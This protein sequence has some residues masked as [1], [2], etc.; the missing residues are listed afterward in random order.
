MKLCP[1]HRS[2]IAMSGRVAQVPGEVSRIIEDAWPRRQVAR[3]SKI[4]L[5][6]KKLCPVHRS[7]IAMSGR[8]AQVPGEA[9]RTIEDEW[10][11]CL[12]FGRLGERP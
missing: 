7:L 12:A 2:L 4:I 10:P 6:H 8:V 3:S 11:R 1:V 5:S 9:S